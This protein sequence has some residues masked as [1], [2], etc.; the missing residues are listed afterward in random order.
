MRQT[1]RWG[2]TKLILIALS[3]KTKTITENYGHSKSFCAFAG[4]CFVAVVLAQLL[5][6]VVVAAVVVRGGIRALVGHSAW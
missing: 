1:K 5:C 6:C 4:K 2:E 3:V